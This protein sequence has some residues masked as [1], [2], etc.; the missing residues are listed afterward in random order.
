M[1]KLLSGTF[2]NNGI[3]LGHA[4]ILMNRNNHASKFEVIFKVDES[5]EWSFY[6]ENNVCLTYDERVD[7]ENWFTSEP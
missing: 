7:F 2:F 3:D 1:F 5:G 6:Y 4:V